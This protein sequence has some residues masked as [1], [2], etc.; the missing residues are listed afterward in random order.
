[1][2]RRPPRSTLFPYTTLFRSRRPRARARDGAPPTVRARTETRRR[3]GWPPGSAR[4][5]A[6]SRRGPLE[7][8]RV[9]A[10]RG[11]RLRS[12][13]RTPRSLRRAGPAGRARS[14]RRR[15]GARRCSSPGRGKTRARRTRSG[16]S[17][18]L[19]PGVD[20]GQLDEQRLELLF[21]LGLG[22][23]SLGVLE[24]LDLLLEILSVGRKRFLLGACLAAGAL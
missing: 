22:H 12:D 18:L 13:R 20:L 3:A 7:P 16:S 14:S 6:A 5:A 23:R 4:S 19:Q 1:M 17:F 2:I 9:P 21:V 24:R 8:A 11:A 15:R 10:G